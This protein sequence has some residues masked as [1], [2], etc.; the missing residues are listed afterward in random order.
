M[1]ASF[2][3]KRGNY[4]EVISWSFYDF[5]NSAFA[6]SILAVI[7]N[8]YYAE[9]A[10][11][12]PSGVILNV[13]G[14]GLRIPGASMFFIIVA[15]SMALVT[16]T[17][18]IIGAMADY[19][20][21]KKRWLLSLCISGAAATGFLYYVGEGD[22]I[23]GGILFIIANYSFAAGNVFYN[24][25]LIDI[26]HPDDMGKISGWGWGLGYLG[27]GLCLVLNLIMLKNPQLIGFREGAFEVVHIFPVV[28]LWWLVFSIPLFVK[29]REAGVPVKLKENIL[30]V[31]LA[32]LNRT[33]HEVKKYR[34]LVRFLLAYLLFN[35]GIETVIITASIF[36]VEELSFQPSQLIVFFLIVQG[37]AF[38][39]SFIF[40]YLVDW[41]GNKKAL[42]ISIMIWSLVVL[43]ARFLGLFMA[44]GKEFYLLGVLAGSVLG[45]SQSA[46]RAL[47]GSFTPQGRG[48]E[49]FGFFAI[50]GK[51]AAILG[52][53]IN[54]IVVIITG[55]VRSAIL[56]LLA[57]FIIGGIILY[58]VDEEEGIRAAVNE[59]S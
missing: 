41:L 5:A 22:Y 45:G 35:E 28:G 44:E 57:F 15:I 53:A 43:W 29:V 48:A 36:A 55:S 54:A 58:F 8:Q 52:P 25:L 21:S 32:R 39:G 49:F 40:G 23:S 56:I 46:A 16:I 50:C 26:S 12:G 17:A 14:S 9:V 42:L 19:S 51:F 20:A 4:G 47:Q 3:L 13:F 24:A 6:T 30:K 7:F 33:F 1:S 2:R 37:S 38:I 59:T 27:G 11:Y 18:P 31:S 34:Q 10:A